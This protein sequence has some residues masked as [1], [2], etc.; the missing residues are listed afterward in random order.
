[1]G[2]IIAICSHYL[3]HPLATDSHFGLRLKLL[4]KDAKKQKGPS[5]VRELCLCWTS[6]ENTIIRPRCLAGT[7]QPVE[8][9]TEWHVVNLLKL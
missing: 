4:G 2:D 9:I 7:E 1:M 8:R 6:D 5:A 3:C